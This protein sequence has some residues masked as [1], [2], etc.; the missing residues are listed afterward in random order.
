MEEILMATVSWQITKET[1]VPE[2][3]Y[4]VTKQV[5]VER[6]ESD[7]EV[8]MQ[9]EAWL[10]YAYQITL[11][12][13]FILGGL[14][15]GIFFGCLAEE[16]DPR[17]WFACAGVVVTAIFGM[18]FIIPALVKWEDRCYEQLNAYQ[19]EHDV[20]NSPELV[21]EVKAYNAEQERIAEEWRAAHPLEEKIRACIK[22]PKSSVEIADLARFYAKEY[23]LMEKSN[24]TLD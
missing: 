15:G 18:C 13:L 19:N 22:D 17:Y 4:F 8:R 20:W 23:I 16:H 10:A 24:E 12:T 3:N 2:K 1:F 9:K 7:F 5:R 14:F 21:K 6:E 11:W